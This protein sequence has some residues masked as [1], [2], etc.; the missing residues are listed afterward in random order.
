MMYEGVAVYSAIWLSDMADDAKMIAH[1]M[2]A[3]YY[4]IALNSMNASLATAPPMEHAAIRDRMK[5]VQVNQTAELNDAASIRRFY[6]WW[7]LGFGGFQTAFVLA[8]SLL[9]AFMVARA[10]RYIHMSML[11]A[12]S[13]IT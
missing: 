10:S 8:Y 2:E 13:T 12:K 5:V 11:G 7:Y 6:L 1:F 4:Q 9:F 3:F